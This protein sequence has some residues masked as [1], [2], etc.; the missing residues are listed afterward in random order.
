METLQSDLEQA[1][2]NRGEAE[3]AAAEGRQRRAEES[4][5]GRRAYTVRRASY[6][7]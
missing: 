2:A 6:R 4:R 3:K 5:G 1:R 7:A